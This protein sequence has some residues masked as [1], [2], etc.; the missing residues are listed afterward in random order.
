MGGRK[1][2]WGWV[3]L[4]SAALLWPG[5]GMRR[6]GCCSLGDRAVGGLPLECGALSI[7]KKGVTHG[8]RGLL[9]YLVRVALCHFSISSFPFGGFEPDNLENN[10]GDN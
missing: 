3:P 1:G 9:S 2:T 5:D 10:S 4:S 7:P 6:R 8:R